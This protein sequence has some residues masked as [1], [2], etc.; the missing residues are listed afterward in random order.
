MFRSFHKEP[1][2][3]SAKVVPLQPASA[4][5]APAIANVD[6]SVYLENTFVRG[7]DVVV[8]NGNAITLTW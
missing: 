2:Q 8:E 7:Y 1:A 4:V 6:R 5:D 3:P